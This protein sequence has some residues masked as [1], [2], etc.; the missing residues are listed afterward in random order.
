M[1]HHLYGIYDQKAQCLVNTFMSLSDAAA[2]RTFKALFTTVEDSVFTGTPS[3]FNLV[4]II[5]IDDQKLPEG[6]SVVVFGSQYSSD[7]LH[8]ERIK[9]AERRAELETAYRNKKFEHV[10]EILN[11]EPRMSTDPKEVKI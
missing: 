3:D 6:S 4:K 5:D 10:K 11:D 9:S 1:I 8:S 7:L 2:E